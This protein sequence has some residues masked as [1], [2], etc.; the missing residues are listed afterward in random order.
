[1]PYRL[2]ALA[3]VAV[4][5]ILQPC[6]ALQPEVHHPL[7]SLAPDE[8]WK[9]Y[10]TLNA[11]GKLGEKTLFS[12][13]LLEEP[14]KA[15]V[16]AWKP[17]DPIVRKVDVV[18]YDE[19]KSFAAVVD[20][21]AGKID[22]YI[23]LTKDQAPMTP[24]ESHGMGDEIKKDPRVQAALKAR[25]ITD[26]RMVDCYVEPA[27]FV[28]L[29]EQT[30]GRR[31][32]WGGCEYSTNAL[33]D[34]DREI[35]G[36]FYTFDLKEKKITR[37][38]DSGAVPMPAP[39]SFYDTD[40][41]PAFSGT[42]PLLTSEPEGPSFTIKDGEVSWENWRFRFRLDARLGPIVNL[43]SYEDIGSAARCFTK[44]ISEM[45]VPYQDPDI[46][47]NKNVY[48]DAG[49]YFSAPI[50]RHH[51]AAARRGRIALCTPTSSAGHFSTTM[52]PRTFARIWPV[53]LSASP[54]VL[55]ASLRQ[56]NR[57]RRCRKNWWAP[58]WAPLP[59][60]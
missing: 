14:P 55:L 30:E 17:G 6:F 60:Q 15:L 57:R 40:G 23:E 50:R 46:S 25:G 7:D 22:S 42:K 51:Q 49:D 8:Y 32:G 35:A 36:I 5:F 56:L 52:A 53:C 34:W 26:M 44:T 4:L 33:Y 29:P 47:W 54:A 37:F 24:S 10:N 38:I 12:S 39:T 21:N 18:L 43:V 9:V 27:G 41:G 20:V 3:F 45:Y 1:M 48:L 59:S 2:K 31:I 19:G 28:D 11:A 16:L 13:I 58:A